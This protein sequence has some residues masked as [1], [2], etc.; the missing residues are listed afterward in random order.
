MSPCDET[1]DPVAILDQQRPIGAHLVI[2]RVDR[3]LV[4]ERA[5]HGAPDIA[6]QQL[7]A[8]EHDDAEQPQRDQRQ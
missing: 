7:A 4:G 1:G 3:P 5:E 6:R 2:E 8:G